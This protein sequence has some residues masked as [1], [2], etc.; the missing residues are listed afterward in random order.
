MKIIALPMKASNTN[1][2]HTPVLPRK[3]FELEH[4]NMEPLS[5][6]SCSSS[7][8]HHFGL[9]PRIISSSPKLRVYNV[10][11]TAFGVLKPFS[12]RQPF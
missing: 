7:H 10:A 5:E 12:H 4:N 9:V 8:S 3:R 1:T 6:P 2:K 11:V